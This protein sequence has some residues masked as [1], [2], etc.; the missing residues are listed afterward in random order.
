MRSCDAWW[1]SSWVRG[2][3]V[4]DVI[5]KGRPFVYRPGDS[6]RDLFI[7]DRWRSLNNPKK[8]HVFTIPKR[9]LDI[10]TREMLC[11]F[12]FFCG[13]QGQIDYCFSRDF[14]LH[15]QFQG[16]I[17]LRKGPVTSRGGGKSK[18]T[19]K[20][21]TNHKGGDVHE[22]IWKNT[23]LWVWPLPSNSGK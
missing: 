11:F 18:E 9:S 12:C 7:P 15:Q 6:I 20:I 1:R 5:G 4:I 8:G 23:I 3:D 19:F 22:K 21:Y 2:R 17:F 13:P 16:T 14:L 10:I